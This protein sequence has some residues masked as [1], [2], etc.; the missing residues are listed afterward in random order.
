GLASF[1]VVMAIQARAI[2]RERDRAERVSEFLVEL[3]KVS[4]PSEARGNSITARE[5]LDRGAQRID[6][7]LK[8]EPLVQAQMMLTM[9]LVYRNLGLPKKVAPLLSRAAD[10]RVRLL[11]P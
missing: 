10:I 2:A 7:E 5:V 3:F 9:G 11:G 1:G 6:K 4:D 8:A